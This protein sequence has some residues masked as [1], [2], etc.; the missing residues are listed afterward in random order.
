MITIID[1]G[2]SN[3]GSVLAAMEEFA[4]EA[5]IAKVA[6]SETLHFVILSL[7]KTWLITWTAVIGVVVGVIPGAGASIASFVAYQQSRTYSKTPEKYGTGHIEG[8]VAPESA[9]NGVTSGTLVPLLILGIP[10]LALLSLIVFVCSFIPVVGVF[11]SSVPICLVALKVGGLPLVLA[12]VAFAAWLV[13]GVPSANKWRPQG[14]RAGRQ[15]SV[16]ARS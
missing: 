15:S 8:L 14:S 7:R 9:N 5:S 16:A 6:G 4:I 12:A 13:R 3:L 10:S 1:S 11:L 2:I